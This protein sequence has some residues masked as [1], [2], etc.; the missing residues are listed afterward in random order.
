MIEHIMF[1]I[2]GHE[3]CKYCTQAKELLNANNIEFLYESLFLKYGEENWRSVF[4]VL[5][6]KIKGQKS[7]PIV[8][9]CDDN[10]TKVNLDNLDESWNL[11]GTY[12]DLVNYVDN[13]Q[14]TIDDDY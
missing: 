9:T 13:M 10:E 6:D 11:V 4:T 2:L 14:L 1:L 7:I 5:N 8:F 12:Q 3:K